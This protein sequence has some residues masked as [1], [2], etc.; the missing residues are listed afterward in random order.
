ML[1]A[2]TVT[3]A[4][5]A[6]G[7]EMAALAHRL[8]SLA[9]PGP[10]RDLGS[11][12]AVL[13]ITHSKRNGDDYVHSSVRVGEHISLCRH[14]CKP[15]ANAVD[16]LMQLPVV[17]GEDL[18]V[19]LVTDAEYSF[20][21]FDAT[22][23]PVAM[24][25]TPTSFTVNSAVRRVHLVR[26][27]DAQKQYTLLLTFEPGQASVLQDITSS[28][29]QAVRELRTDLARSADALDAT[30][31]AITLGHVAVE[32]VSVRPG[33]VTAEELDRQLL[34]M[35]RDMAATKHETDAC[36]RLMQV[37]ETSA[38]LDMFGGQ[39]G[40]R[41]ADSAVLHFE[42]GTVD[43]MAAC[44]DRANVSVHAVAGAVTHLRVGTLDASGDALEYFARR[45]L[46]DPAR[47][48]DF[49]RSMNTLTRARRV[50]LDCVRHSDAHRSPLHNGTEVRARYLVLN[51]IDA[52]IVRHVHAM[53]GLAPP[54]YIDM[55]SYPFQLRQIRAS[56]VDTHNAFD[57]ASYEAAMALMAKAIGVSDVARFCCACPDT[58][59]SLTSHIHKQCLVTCIADRQLRVADG[60]NYVYSAKYNRQLDATGVFENNHLAAEAEMASTVAGFT[61]IISSDAHNRIIPKILHSF[62]MQQTISASK[63]A[64]SA[65]N[66]AVMDRIVAIFDDDIKPLARHALLREALPADAMAFR[67]DVR[68]RTGYDERLKAV[69]ILDLLT[70]PARK[71][72]IAPGAYTPAPASICSTRTPTS[73][74]RAG[75]R[76][77]T[78][79]SAGCGG[80]SRKS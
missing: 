21:A 49:A 62:V 64:P 36:R 78:R 37:P 22:G 44:L 38:L 20:A 52:V 70:G 18:T 10:R 9:E 39:S 66:R 32:S 67:Q 2:D 73:T 74:P 50:V 55:E 3:S 80:V 47:V 79:Y 25:S 15:T 75:Q 56:C 48:H 28:D 6:H 14:I 41:L 16:Y 51:C 77:A 57:E 68:P 45:Q 65:A 26:R 30:I 43:R 58:A 71:N 35:D 4:L 42:P 61:D 31:A 53:C 12:R 40:F 60:A 63:N 11:Q 72:E 23:D 69:M 46:G 8:Q 76:T 33:T 13:A 1:A 34:S 24:P 7:L 17:P 19:E 27:I 54:R 5:C 59:L 29:A